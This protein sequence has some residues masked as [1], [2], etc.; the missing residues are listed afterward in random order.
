MKDVWLR[1]DCVLFGNFLDK[2]L[3]RSFREKVR[4]VGI[5]TEAG[6][7]FEFRLFRGLGS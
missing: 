7:L 5:R 2:V 6:Q 4:V 3:E 1:Q